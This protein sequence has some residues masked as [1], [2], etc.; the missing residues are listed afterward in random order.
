MLLMVVED[1]PVGLDLNET[2]VFLHAVRQVMLMETWR[3][4]I[5]VGA[6]CNVS[7]ARSQALHEPS[8]VLNP[9]PRMKPLNL[10]MLGAVALLVGGVALGTVLT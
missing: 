2:V 6:S 7:T 3:S 10:G 1:V 8:L 5:V 4:V 9:N